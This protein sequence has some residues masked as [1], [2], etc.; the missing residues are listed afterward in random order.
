MSRARFE[1]GSN[2]EAVLAVVT[3]VILVQLS[4]KRRVTYWTTT[5]QFPVGAVVFVCHQHFARN[6]LYP[7]QRITAVESVV[8]WNICCELIFL[9]CTI[10]SAVLLANQAVIVCS[11]AWLC[12]IYVSCSYYIHASRLHLVYKCLEIQRFTKIRRRR[13]NLGF[14][15]IDRECSCGPLPCSVYG[16]GKIDSPELWEPQCC[17]GMDSTV[18]IRE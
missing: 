4:V 18:Q 12:M 7:T 2:Y 17:Y 16:T 6:C 11:F 5:V 9:L 8:Q 3:L 14:D 10:C 1:P 13:W 15:V